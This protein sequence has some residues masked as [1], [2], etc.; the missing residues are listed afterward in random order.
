MNITIETR[1]DRKRGCGWRQPGGKYL[2]AG[3]LS[4][5]CGKLPLALDVCPTCHQGIKPTRGWT[6]VGPGPLFE[7]RACAFPVHIPHECS[8]CPLDKPESLGKAGLLWIGGKF[9][10]APGDFWREAKLQGVSRRIAAIPKDFQVG[11]TWVLLAHRKAISRTCPVC[12]GA[13]HYPQTC[14]YRERGLA[15]ETCEECDGEGRFYTPGIFHA[16]CP[17]AIEYVVKGDEADEELER[18]VK[19][20]CTLVRVE[21]VGEQQELIAV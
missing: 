6:W 21:R 13:G 7:G 20:G 17:T 10:P 4:S 3:S 12:N 2:V 1:R 18:L 14:Y 15:G 9:Y 5:P 8:P 19:Q 11:V 16:F